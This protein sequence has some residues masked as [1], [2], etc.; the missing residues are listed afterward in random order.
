MG[1]EALNG[2]RVRRDFV[3]SLAETFVH[4]GL[5]M[6]DIPYYMCGS[7]KR[8]RP[9]CGDIEIVFH[10]NDG[11]TLF[12]LKQ[13]I[14]K[15]FGYNS[16]NYEAKMQGL[17]GEVQFDLFI[18][19][20]SSLGAM[21]MHATGSGLFNIKMRAIA[22]SRGLKLNQYGLYRISDSMPVVLGKD[23]RT[24]FDYLGVRY[25]EPSERDIK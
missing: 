25:H 11:E 14:G 2:R 4:A 16:T 10:V 12:V 5:G 8:G 19:D 7:Y 21:L 1:G 13:R 6:P 15:I 17:Y 22:K 24:I 18:A 9:D 3:E 20:D 23:E